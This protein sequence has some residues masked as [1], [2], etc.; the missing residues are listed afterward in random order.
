MEVKVRRTKE[1]IE[2]L[3]PDG[4]QILGYSLKLW[5]VLCKEI[6]KEIENGKKN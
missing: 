3:R 2:F 1:K 4:S 6:K 5:K